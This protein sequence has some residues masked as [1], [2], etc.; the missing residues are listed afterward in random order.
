M[1]NLSMG[2]VFQLTRDT[3]KTVG[4]DEITLEA[5]TRMRVV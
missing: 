5:G 1:K 4:D 2:A 3:M